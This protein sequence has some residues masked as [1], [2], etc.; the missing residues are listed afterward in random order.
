MNGEGK[1]MPNTKSDIYIIPTKPCPPI[2]MDKGCND[3][4][5]S[6]EYLQL[7][8]RMLEKDV[9][10]AVTEYAAATNETC[11]LVK[12]NPLEAV[13]FNDLKEETIRLYY[14]PFFKYDAGAVQ[15][16]KP[17]PL[18]VY[19][20]AVGQ[21]IVFHEKEF[22]GKVSDM[23]SGKS[24]YPIEIECEV[25]AAILSYYFRNL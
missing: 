15:F 22:L 10:G 9:N 25:Y 2:L 16:I 14:S 21:L 19:N 1:P 5:I 7:F 23:M 4:L 6:V 13:S 8:T 24:Q 3:A 17:E 20:K 18:K 11:S 12:C